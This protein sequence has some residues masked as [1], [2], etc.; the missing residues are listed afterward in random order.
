MSGREG[1]SRG[2]RR[3]R[4]MLVLGG[5]VAALFVLR[6]RKLAESEAELSG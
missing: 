5:I 1:G 2:A 6:S 4:R 3:L